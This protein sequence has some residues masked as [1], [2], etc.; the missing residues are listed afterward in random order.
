MGLLLGASVMS[1]AEIF[2]WMFFLRFKMKLHLNQAPEEDQQE[3]AKVNSNVT[4]SE[5]KM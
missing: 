1:L 3:L 2:D 5:I 4:L